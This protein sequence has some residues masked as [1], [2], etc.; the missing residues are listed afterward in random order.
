MLLS[1]NWLKDH[2]VKP[3]FP[4]TPEELAEKLTMIGLPVES[5][6]KGS[7]G[8][9][10]VVAGRI[11]QIE[12]HPN[13]DKLQVT[14]VVT[15]EAEGA[16]RR[17][18]VCGA[19]NIVVGD[20]VPVALPGTILPGNVKIAV[21]KIRGIESF[22]MLCSGRELQIS[23]DSEGILKLPKNSALGQPLSALLGSDD[24]IFDFEL[25][26]DR[27]D[28]QS[29]IGLARE[30]APLVKTRLRDLKPP[31]FKITPHRT[32]SIIK[33]EIEDSRLCP[34]YVARVIDHLTVKESPHWMQLKLKAVG[35]RPINN[36]V[37]ITNYVMYEFGIPL[38]A[39]DLRRIESGGIRVG[40]AKEEMNFEL[41]G[42][43]TER[44]LP[45][46]IMIWDGNRPIAL[47]GIMGGANSQ[48]Q[49]DTTSILLE[50]ACFHAPTIRKTAKRLKLQTE[51][52]KRFEK[53]VDVVAV[54][55]ASDR[56]AAFL[57]DDYEATVYHPPIDT[58]DNPYQEQSI[59]IDMREVRRITGLENLTT[60]RAAN[61]LESIELISHRKSPNILAIRLPSF[62][63]DL[64]EGIDITGEIAR[65][66]GYESIPQT[67]PHSSSAFDRLDD[68]QIRFEFL[69]RDLL[70]KHGLHETIH[71]SF[72]S[73]TQLR[74]F[75][76]FPEAPVTL[77]NPITEELK[78]LRP[79]L[80]GS[81]LQTY[82]YNWNR[83][84]AQQRLFEVANTYSWDPITPDTGIREAPTAAGLLSGNVTRTDWKL[85][86]PPVDFYFG[87]GLIDLL[88]RQL[89][90]IYLAYDPCPNHS[91]FHP[92]RSAIIKLG[93]REVGYLGEIHP[94]VA[95]EILKTD[96]AI[97]L[98]EIDL[99]ALRR[100]SRGPVR[101]KAPPKFPAM[102]LDIALVVDKGLFNQT[103]VDS[104]K[105]SGGNLLSHVEVFDIYEGENMPMG[106]KSI[107]F[108][109]VFQS[110]DRTLLES[111]AEELKNKI[112]AH[113]KERHGAQLRE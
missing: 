90:T 9:A 47:A 56:A 70:A 101:Y 38:H 37:D 4:P 103:L 2:L 60:E 75:G 72:T 20:I 83:D 95:K 108:H 10:Q 96:E 43:Q 41:L 8:L 66:V 82:Q 12:K 39:F 112:V 7:P 6:Q 81:L 99:E 19:T 33:V 88:V 74:Q 87:K 49:E 80:L 40:P 42:G 106:K 28:C 1:L 34:R 22:G 5:I 105:Q 78:I 98:F 44:I 69:A 53:G 26:A 62:R 21:S 86:A 97:V 76:L 11:E 113:L 84:I 46:D 63:L 52:S 64:K 79:S 68:S 57:Q 50:S 109:L 27:P 15:S 48:I 73:E 35:I 107:A 16:E 30:I 54:L 100:F 65:L 55:A 77:Q 92:K 91:L 102:T 93:L 31:R 3:N 29:V 71:F 13:A 32:S 14:W 67:Y 36:I 25:T 59:T 85:Q 104:I 51:S 17:Q 24:I 110:P 89:T 58:N 23:E 111:E 18:I 94:H 61:A 45:G